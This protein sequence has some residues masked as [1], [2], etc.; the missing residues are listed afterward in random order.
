MQFLYCH[1]Q[2]LSSGVQYKHRDQTLS[3]RGVLQE[4]KTTEILPESLLELVVTF[5]KGS[6]CIETVVVINFGVGGR[7]W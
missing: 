5:T 7:T 3:R 2:T 4:V 6:D 1:L